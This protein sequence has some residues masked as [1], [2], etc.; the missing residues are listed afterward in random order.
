VN[1]KKEN[2]Y[3]LISEGSLTF[4]PDSKRIAYVAAVK[5]GIGYDYDHFVVVDGKELFAFNFDM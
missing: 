3:D 4:S 2:E 5:Q 1:G